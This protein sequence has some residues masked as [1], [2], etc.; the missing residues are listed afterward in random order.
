MKFYWDTG[1][2]MGVKGLI[3]WKNLISWNIYIT[4]SRNK[5]L[6]S[7]FTSLN[8]PPIL[9]S[10]FLFFPFLY[11]FIFY[12]SFFFSLIS[13]SVSSCYSFSILFLLNV[14]YNLD[15]SQSVPSFLSIYLYIY[16]SQSVPIYLS[17]SVLIYLSIYLSIYYNLFTSSYLSIYHSSSINSKNCRIQLFY[18]T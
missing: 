14:Y 12:I 6:V 10:L 18:D 16:L 2:Q 13:L 15:L 9:L 4:M 7:L 5:F 8:S 17:Q 3:I 1:V 11:T